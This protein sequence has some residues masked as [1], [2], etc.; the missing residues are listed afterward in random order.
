M[1]CGVPVLGADLPPISSYILA[2]GSGKV[3]DS[4]IPEAFAAGVLE[5]LSDEYEWERMSM[6]GRKAV[7]EDWNWNSMEDKLFKVYEKLKDSGA[8][9]VKER[10]FYEDC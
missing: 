6:A 7:Q 1:A 9:G 2:A 5:I 10:R 4:A 8:L 3:F